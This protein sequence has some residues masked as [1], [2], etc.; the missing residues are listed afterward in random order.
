MEDRYALLIGNSEY[1]GNAFRRLDGV[2]YDVDAVAEVLRSHGYEVELLRDLP[3][4]R[5]GDEIERF[6]KRNGQKK[7]SS[8]VFY[9]AGHGVSVPN[10]AG[11]EQGYL[12]PVDTP[13]PAADST[14]FLNALLPIYEFGN[15]AQRMQARHALFLFDA[16]FAGTIFKDLGLERDDTPPPAV[17][18]LLA[19]PARSVITSGSA[20]QK[21]PDESL[22]RLHLVRALSGEAGSFGDG[23]LTGEE[24]GSFLRASV[25]NEGGGQ[26]RPQFG[27]LMLAGLAE[28]DFV[29]SLSAIARSA[30][31]AKAFRRWLDDT[32]DTTPQLKKAEPSE[33]S[34]F[35]FMQ[36]G[37]GAAEEYDADDNLLA[38]DRMNV[39]KVFLDAFSE[40]LGAVTE[41]DTMRETAIERYDHWRRL[42]K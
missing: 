28:G 6:I 40:D 35:L 14:A 3:S 32:R 39:W 19:R 37:F 11:V 38:E 34:L 29:F 5:M 24:L 9:Y 18:D 17:A 16:C 15:Y 22:F 7:N 2:R 31:A 12:V 13:P 42:A 21:V 27:K 26:Q 8:V 36:M 10:I 33:K 4:E 20:G 25:M 23:F 1:D 41:D 30:S